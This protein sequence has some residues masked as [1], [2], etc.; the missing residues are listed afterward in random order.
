MRRRCDAEKNEDICESVG[1][2]YGKDCNAE[3]YNGE[4]R[5]DTHSAGYRWKKFK[6][7][8]NRERYGMN[9]Y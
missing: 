1:E 5:R 4:E 7:G 6:A 3:V 2:P 8:T 9:D